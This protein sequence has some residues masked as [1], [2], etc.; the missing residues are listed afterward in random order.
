MRAE[1]GPRGVPSATGLPATGLP[2]GAAGDVAAAVVR[3]AEA[4]E[5][6]LDR[7]TAAAVEAIWDQ[8]P[9][10][11]NSADKRL[12]DDVTGHV[13]A[14][15][16]VWLATL[17]EQRP[18]RRADFAIT[19][20]QATLRIRQGISLADFLQAF[21]IGQ[22]TMWHSVLETV[23][24]DPEAREAALAVVE[25][26]MR[27]IEVG[28]TVAAEAYLDAQ[29]HQ[30]ADSDRVRRDLLEDLLTRRSPAAGPKQ[31]MLRAAGLEP[32]RS[33]LVV[34]AAP[35]API[36]ANHTLSEAVAM[37]RKARGQGAGGLGVVRQEEIVAIFPAT[38]EPCR[39]RRGERAAGVRGPRA[40]AVAARCRGEHRACR[41]ARGPGGVRRGAHRPRRP[42]R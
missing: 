35:V 40:P 2:A 33:L 12:R 25:Y 31:A 6:S 34:S 24:D 38:R 19:R 23:R 3:I 17:T 20:D 28:S 4:V 13:E 36:G 30:L 11:R 26:I 16:R 14:V 41:A 29:Q 5:A 9:A 37:L 18:A 21:R 22:L 42:G 32:G 7:V 10:Y 39:G 15:F 1:A 8:A 27:V